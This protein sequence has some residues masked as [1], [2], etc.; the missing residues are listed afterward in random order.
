MNSE[1]KAFRCSLRD[2]SHPSIVVALT[3]GKARL[4]MV[5]SANDAGFWLKFTELRVNR[6]HEYD[7]LALP[8]P[9]SRHFP[10][11]RPVIMGDLMTLQL[12]TCNCTRCQQAATTAPNA[13]DKPR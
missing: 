9:C 4:A 8:L 6:A 1:Y 5:R 13:Q 10:R 3:R 2:G 11:N 12:G 7:E